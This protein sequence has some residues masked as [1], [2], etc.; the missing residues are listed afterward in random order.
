[1]DFKRFCDNAEIPCEKTDP[2]RFFNPGMCDGAFITKEYT[3]DAQILK[4]WFL[5]EISKYP[6][7][8]IV[9]HHSP[10]RIEKRGSCWRVIS[11]EIEALT[12]FILNSTYASVNEILKITEG[13]MTL[14]NIKYEKCEIILCSV[15]EKMKN[16]GITVMDGPF[17][18]L[19]PFGNTGFH[20]LT[21]VTFTPHET[22]YDTVA[23]FSC[24]NESKGLCSPGNL[25]N[26]NDCPAKPESAWVY[27]NQLT[28]KYLREEFEYKYEKSLFSMKP[29]LVASEIDDSRPTVIRMNSLLPTMISVLSGKINTLYDLDEVL[30]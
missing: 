26:C 20:S 15:N 22:S 27:M 18:S 19:M 11:Q 4:D 29:I 21:S 23:S 1:M 28:K 6:N 24:Q 17:F 12:P 7:I 30:I 13:G 5:L 3:Y 25:F 2:N 16:Y 10:E 8:E 9:F 14:F